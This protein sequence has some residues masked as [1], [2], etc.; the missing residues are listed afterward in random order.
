MISVLLP[1]WAVGVITFGVMLPIL[2]FWGGCI[3]LPVALLR[4]LIPV[5][6]V[7]EALAG[8]LSAIASQWVASNQLLYRVLLAPNWQTEFREKLDPKKSYL[9]VC[10][11]QAWADI[12]I[13]ADLMHGRMP[14]LRFFLKRELLWV[15]II[16]VGCWA[17][18]MPFMKRHSR[19][20]IA[21]NPALRGEDLATT[22]R[23]CEKF[24]SRPIAVVNFPEG[25]RFS[26][27]K[28]VSRGSPFRHLLRPK[29]AGLS[30]MLNSMGEQFGGII[31]VTIAYQPTGKPLSWSW[32]CGEQ[33]QM[34][35]HVDTIP[36]P[37]DMIHG[38]YEGD[39]AF[40]ARFQE[41][42]NGLWARKD[43]RLERMHTTGQPQ[44]QPRLT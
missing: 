42:V 4:T 9:L 27:A 29:A 3:L 18:D 22:R 13:L 44:A 6:A 15:P 31:D 28:R 25:T 26:E 40:R 43:A 2:I 41:W 24:R 7:Q 38:D 20:A 12:L 32:L 16:G 8:L 37:P 30:F 11:H 14:F 19:E 36:I 33:N 1:A 21:A 10:N 17:L 35:V 34:K 39:E 23:F 5:P